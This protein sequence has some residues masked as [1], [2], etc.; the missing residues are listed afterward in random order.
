[1]QGR[2]VQIVCT[3]GPASREP[4]ILEELVH[5]GMNV[6]RLNAAHG[7]AD[8]HRDNA[9]RIRAASLSCDRPVGILMDLPGPK[10][11][12]GEVPGGSL[13]LT[14][15]ER[16]DLIG[17]AE[18]SEPGSLPVQDPYFHREV[19]AGAPVLL[20][21]GAV[22]L[23]V[24]AVEGRRVRC[25]VVVGGEI[26]SGKGVNAPGAASD[27]PILGARDV[28]ALEL[29][30]EIG[31]DLIGVSFVRSGEDLRAVRRALRAIGRPIPLVA[32]IETARALDHLDDILSAT[33]AVMVA[34]GDLSLEV[35]YAR[36]P[37]AQ[38]RIVRAALRAGRPVITATQ[39]LHSMVS[40]PR[41]TRAEATDVAN[42][43]LDGT[44]A[45]MLSDETA[46]G[47]DPVRAC[48]AMAKIIEE[49][50]AAYP[51]HAQP[52]PEDVQGSGELHELI[53]FA[54]AAVRTAAEV[55]ARAIL[56]WSR[57]G[58][59]ARMVSRER[60]VVPIVAPTRS[61]ESYHRLALPYGIRPILVTRPRLSLSQLESRLGPLPDHALLLL[62]RHRP[63]EHRRIP[64]M[65]L[66]RV[67]D[68][69]EWSIE[70]D[71]VLRNS[72]STP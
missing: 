52:E 50:E 5:A 3:I 60:P 37:V 55:G 1:V 9:A 22:E 24:V 56:I 8:Q 29:A 47:V 58:L 63:G 64:W 66:V 71:A 25:R 26:T 13:L 34:R 49:T 41:P 67:A 15:G 20:G 70:Q 62:V 19:A 54:R 40:A 28:E 4:K 57:G 46:V 27:R 31:V 12:L 30:A 72:Q 18:Q 69:E 45:V 68:V 61:A 53:V 44:D 65:A 43:V 59:A 21:D 42:A 14:P 7:D 51:G 48:R 36:V 32:K 23:E 33:D 16:V 39:M 38:K 17:D 6:A 11:R 2:S 10:L 35:P